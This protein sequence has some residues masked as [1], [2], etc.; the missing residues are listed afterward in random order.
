MTISTKCYLDKLIIAIRDLLK[1][2]YFNRFHK[3]LRDNN[4][5]INNEIFH[6]CKVSLQIILAPNPTPPPPPTPNNMPHHSPITY[7]VTIALAVQ[8]LPV[9]RI[10]LGSLQVYIVT[11]QQ[12]VPSQHGQICKANS[13]NL[14]I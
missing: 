7:Y 11:D 3:T 2:N 9:Q 10:V 4:N 13:A 1:K 5:C 8:D 14:K 6:V 12:S